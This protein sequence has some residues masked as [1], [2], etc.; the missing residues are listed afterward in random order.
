[1]IVVGTVI[2]LVTVTD[3]PSGWL[4]SRVS[5]P[6]NKPMKMDETMRKKSVRI[7]SSWVKGVSGSCSSS[8][9][10]DGA[11]GSVSS[12]GAVSGPYFS[13]FESLER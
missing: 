12:S 9:S 3:P 10:F 11:P 7:K 6:A 4:F 2:V 13:I 1:M 5:A 8:P